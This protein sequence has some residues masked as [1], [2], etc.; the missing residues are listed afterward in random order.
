MEKIILTN[1][2]PSEIIEQLE[3]SQKF[4]GDQIFKWVGNGVKNFD[5]MTNLSLD[6]RN[7]LKDK[8]ILRCTTL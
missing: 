6:L 3:L 7:Q 5:A 4:R 1:L 2:I 8:S